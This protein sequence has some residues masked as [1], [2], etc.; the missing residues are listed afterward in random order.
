MVVHRTDT[1]V[2]LPLA[3]E[4]TLK[5]LAVVLGRCAD[6][7]LGPAQSAPGPDRLDELA[8]GTFWERLDLGQYDIILLEMSSGELAQLA[9]RLSDHPSHQADVF[10]AWRPASAAVV[11]VLSD[12]AVDDAVYAAQ[13]GFDG[14]IAKPFDQKT[15]QLRLQLAWDRYC[16]RTR[17]VQ[18]HYRLRKL[19][20]AVNRKRRQL[21]DQVDLLC[22]DLVSSNVEL[23]RTLHDFRELYDFQT[24]LTGQF[25]LQH[26]LYTALRQIRTRLGQANA[27]VYLCASDDFEAHLTDAWCDGQLDV[28][29]TQDVFNKTVVRRII[30]TGRPMTNVGSDDWPTLR[31]NDRAILG[32]ISLIAV[33]LIAEGQMIGVVIVYRPIADRLSNQDLTTIVPLLGPMAHA[34]CTIGRLQGHIDRVAL[35]IG[36]PLTD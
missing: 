20:G 5:E 7:D 11:A 28:T 15:C 35:S 21:R 12:S 8:D 14:I 33:P 16:R 3:G 24:Q 9:R 2:L 31:Q 18:R 25:D 26:M 13:L 4:N 1:V 23:T 32:K 36:Q 30:A 17:M 29:D 27:A 19:C 10:G 34:V 6:Y 22:R